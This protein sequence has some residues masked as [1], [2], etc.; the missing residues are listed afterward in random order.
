M[1]SEDRAE[2]RIDRRTA[3]ASAGV[4]AAAVTVAACATAEPSSGEVAPGTEVAK[5]ADVPVGG[6]VIAGGTVVTQ[7]QAGVYQ[8]FSAA[9][10]HLGCSVSKIERETIV[11]RCHGS[12]FRFDGTVATGPAER[13]LAPRAVRVD[14]D[15]IVTA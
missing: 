4:A 7:P 8:G 6:A 15:R 10:T 2:L 9:C 12:A 13:P 11:C 14:G 1:T 3:L 5:V